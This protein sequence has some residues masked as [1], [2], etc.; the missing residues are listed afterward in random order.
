MQPA[1]LHPLTNSS[2]YLSVSGMTTSPTSARDLIRR[3]Q[4]DLTALSST[5]T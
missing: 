5:I 2:G 1:V 4:A 3:I